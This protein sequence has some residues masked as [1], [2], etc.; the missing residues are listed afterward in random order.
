MQDIE[1]IVT[2]VAANSDYTLL[3]T[4]TGGYKRIFDVR[5]LLEK[6]IFEPLKNLAFF[7]NAKA[8]CGTVVWSDEVDIAPEYLYENSTPVEGGAL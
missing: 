4:F 5:P 8:E 7:L 3:I 6:K 1:W 2:D